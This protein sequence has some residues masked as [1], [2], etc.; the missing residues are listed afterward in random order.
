MEGGNCSLVIYLLL[1]S[2]IK[3]FAHN[4]LKQ[5]RYEAYRS[6]QHFYSGNGTGEF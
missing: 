2:G 3:P 6:G 5:A 4:P 1:F